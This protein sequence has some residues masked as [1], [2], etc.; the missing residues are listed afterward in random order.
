MLR[1]RSGTSSREVWSNS[2]LPTYVVVVEPKPLAYQHR[3]SDST[4]S[5]YEISS[6][7]HSGD[8][9]T[10]P[11]G[12]YN[13]YDAVFTAHNL[14]PTRI[15]EVGVHMGEST[16]VFSQRYPDAR[17]VGVDLVQNDIDFSGFPQV[18]YLQCDQSDRNKLGAIVKTYFP[19]GIDLVIDDASH[20][21][22]LSRVTF[23]V[24][25]PFVR[26]GGIY[27]IEDWGTGY[28]PGFEDGDRYQEFSVAPSPTGKFPRRLPSFDAGMVGFVKSLVDLTTSCVDPVTLEPL[29]PDPVIER[30]EIYGA[31]VACVK[32]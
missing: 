28:W 22:Y 31:I 30:L 2:Q 17:I 15:L 9:G 21:G 5:L 25:F 13:R 27:L 16:K 20:I 3:M 8:I 11:P 29:M 1:L 19:D 10:K 12:Y 32:K 26:S 24:V 6:E 7:S 23:D 18:T 4:K 14:N